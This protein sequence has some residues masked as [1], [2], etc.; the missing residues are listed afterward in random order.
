MIIRRPPVVFGEV[1]TVGQHAFYQ[2]LHQGDPVVPCDFIVTAKGLP[3]PEG[4]HDKLVANALA[5]AQALAFGH[6]NKAEPHRNFPGNRPST[7]IIL[8]DVTPYT[9]GMLLAFYE[10]KTFVQGV[11]WGVNSFDQW[12]VELGKQLTGPILE[13]L[14]N[15]GNGKTSM[16][17]LDPSTQTL[18]EKILKMA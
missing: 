5:Q 4:H 3:G 16:S 1:G 7:T 6:E 9:L 15:L 12:G 8:P 10:H 18:V 11:L 17:G 14:Q 13:A 2:L